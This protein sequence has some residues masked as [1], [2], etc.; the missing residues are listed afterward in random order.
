MGIKI[1]ITNYQ[2]QTEIIR[3]RTKLAR[4]IKIT[5]TYYFVY[6]FYI[7]FNR[8]D[9]LYYKVILFSFDFFYFNFF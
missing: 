5:K 3:N 2:N 1:Y 8:L 9:D 7:F 4:L 6:V